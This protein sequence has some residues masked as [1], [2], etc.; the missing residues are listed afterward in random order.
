[1]EAQKTKHTA[2]RGLFPLGSTRLDDVGGSTRIQHRSKNTRYEY[3]IEKKF[4]NCLT[5]YDPHKI[6]GSSPEERTTQKQ[7][8]IQGGTHLS[9]TTLNSLC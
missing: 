8:K 7:L 4:I 6:Q 2:V 9:C 3:S 1:M 5:C